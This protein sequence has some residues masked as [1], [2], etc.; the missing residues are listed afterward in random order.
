MRTAILAAFA[1]I[2]LA[3]SA[4]ADDTKPPQ[5]SDVKASHKGG[6]VTVEA[7]ITDE[8]GVLSAIC[9]HR[10]PGGKVEDA[11][12]VKNDYDDVFKATFNGG[13][14]S[15]YWIESSDLLGNG[16]STYGSASKAYAV[17]GGKTSGGSRVAAK[18]KEESPKEE[19]APKEE[20]PKEEAP[21]PREHHRERVAKA[22]EPP[23]IEHRKPSIQPPEGK[24]F[25][26]RMKIKS[27]SPVA[28]AILQAKPEGGANQ[29]IQ[30]THTEGDS[31]EGSIPAAIA[32]GTVDYWIAAKNQAGMMTRQ[33]DGD[34]STPYAITFK[35]AGG[36]TAV[37]ASSSAGAAGAQPYTF[38][39][40]PPYRVMPGKAFVVR[41]QVVPAADDGQSPDRVAVLWRGADA[42]DQITDMVKDDTG[43]LGG[44]KAELPEQPEGAV[45]FQVV[46]CDQAAT[47]CAV[48]TGSKHKWHATI[49]ASSPGAAQPMAL[50]A[51][52]SKGPPSLPE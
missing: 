9:H 1:A 50:D 7:R 39:D 43:G 32:H 42:Q 14:E 17:G 49:V 29:N 52:S 24:D 2:F 16:P 35:S 20:A 15:E 41:A 6:K 36:S 3:F 19:A 10:T 45:F 18:E 31:Y 11:Q 13:N 12:M 27:E 25:T 48:D 37:A 28:V 4:R 8:T 44:Y 40:L 22:A 23:V 21:P 26:L 30:L 38:T 33:G 47:K 51:V 46:A 5:I 34:A